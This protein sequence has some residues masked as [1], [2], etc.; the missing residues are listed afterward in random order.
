MD[1]GPLQLEMVRVAPPQPGA[2]SCCQSSTPARR[3]PP[4]R[5]VQPS[6]ASLLH[7]CA[8]QGWQRAK[9]ARACWALHTTH[10]ASL[11]LN[12]ALVR[13]PRRAEGAQPRRVCPYT[14][15]AACAAHYYGN[16]TYATASSPTKSP[17]RARRK[18]AE[19]HAQL[20]RL[21]RAP[22]CLFFSFWGTGTPHQAPGIPACAA[23]PALHAY[24]PR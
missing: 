8:T 23:T 10:S 2:S 19:L 24:T 3:T 21:C 13:R 20:Y 18:A 5:R 14:H 15:Q 17:R 4:Q 16:A 7:V 11:S 6:S 1:R 9:A 22:S 12:I